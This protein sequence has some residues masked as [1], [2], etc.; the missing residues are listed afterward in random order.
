MTKKLEDTLIERVAEDRDRLIKLLIKLDKI[1]EYNEEKALFVA[2]NI[3]KLSDSLTKQNAQLLELIKLQQKE[4]E[5][6]EK[7]DKDFS[8]D[9]TN[10]MYGQ[11]EK[12]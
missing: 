4:K 7:E 9:E 6:Q 3:S 1:I 8:L 10:E 5:K 12:Q 2:D 11:M